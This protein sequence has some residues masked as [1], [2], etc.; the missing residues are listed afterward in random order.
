[1]RKPIKPV[2]A[3][4]LSAIIFGFI[5]LP[6]VSL[7]QLGFEPS[8]TD[9]MIQMD[10]QGPMALEPFLKYLAPRLKVNFNYSAEVG[11][12]QITIKTPAQVPASTLPLL[13]SGVLKSA[14][15]GLI[16]E[17]VPGWITINR[18]L[19]LRTIW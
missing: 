2:Q 16:K 18:V 10:L 5:G 11:A 1:M 14:G 3:A 19:P 12:K 15:L 6:S 8:P 17:D 9:T 7:G 13:L 4:I